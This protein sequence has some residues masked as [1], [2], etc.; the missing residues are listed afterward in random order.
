MSP[1]NTFGPGEGNV[2]NLICVILCMIHKDDIVIDYIFMIADVIIL[3]ITWSPY[4]QMENGLIEILLLF[5][6]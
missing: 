2:E 4:L 1:T 5:R 6:N 3:K